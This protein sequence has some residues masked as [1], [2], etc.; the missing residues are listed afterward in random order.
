MVDKVVSL[1]EV[2]EHPFMLRNL[3]HRINNITV[4]SIAHTNPVSRTTAFV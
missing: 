3:L 2:S 4:K 1:V